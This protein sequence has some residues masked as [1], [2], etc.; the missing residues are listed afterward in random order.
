MVV[1]KKNERAINRTPKTKKHVERYKELYYYR[2]E[3]RICTTQQQHK[4]HPRRLFFGSIY[5]KLCNY[6]YI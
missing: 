4:K 6:I 5:M 1:K 2:I 3:M